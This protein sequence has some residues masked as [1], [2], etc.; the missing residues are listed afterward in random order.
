MIR[1]LLLILAARCWAASC[2]RISYHTAAHS[3][4]GCLYAAGTDCAGEYG[5]ALP[6]PTPR[7]RPCRSWIRPSPA[8]C[9]AT[10]V[11]GP[12]QAHRAGQ[13]RLYVGV[14]LHAQR[15]RLLRHQRPRRRPPRSSS[16]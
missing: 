16:T 8:P 9:A 3:D 2:T 13:P 14:I 5:G 1:W 6:L 12:A 15:H 4:A 7:K 10:T 11:A